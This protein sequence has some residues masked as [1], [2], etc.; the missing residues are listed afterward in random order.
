MSSRGG[1]VQ[2][3]RGRPERHPPLDQ[4][5]QR[6]TTS[7]SELRVSVHIHPGPPSGSESS[8]T[9]SLRTGPDVLSD[10]H[11]VRRQLT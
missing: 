8:Q 1:H 3:G 10:V 4:L 2:G 11:N 9:H 5:H 7:R 6:D